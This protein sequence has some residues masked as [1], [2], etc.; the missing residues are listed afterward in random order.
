MKK[1]PRLLLAALAALV[2]AA[3]GTNTMPSA[4]D[5]DRYYAKAEQMAQDR[6]ADLEARKKRGEITQAE[7]EEQSATVRGRILNHATELAWARHENLE[8]RKRAMGIPTGDHP[9]Q[10]IVPGTGGGESFYR[11]AG[12]QGGENFQSNTPY[13]GSTIGG[14]NR[15]D[16]PTLPPLQPPG[17]GA[18]AATG[19]GSS[20]NAGP[21]ARSSPAVLTRTFPCMTSMSARATWLLLP[22]C[23]LLAQC[24]IAHKV[25]Q[26]G[27]DDEPKPAPPDPARRGWALMMSDAEFARFKQG[28]GSGGATSGM[29]PGGP[30]AATG[31]GG[32]MF[33]FSSMLPGQASAGGAVAWQRSAT[34]AAKQARINGTPLL[35]YATH[36]SSVP[37]Q[38]M[39]RTLMASAEFQAL[40]EKFVP[41]LVD[42]S[43]QD[44]SRSDLYRELKNRYDLRGYP[45]LIV[46]LP[47]GTEVTRLTGYNVKTEG[48][49]KTYADT[50][51]RSLTQVDKRTNERRASL[52]RSEGYRLWKNKDGKPVF[53]RLA[54]LDAN[55]GTFTSEWG[56]SFKTFLSRLSEEDQAWIAERRK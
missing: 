48:I 9:V 41:L 19:A 17:T 13:G 40:S 46:A 15:G 55:M 27:K 24:G 14:P 35:I 34:V 25:R 22:C 45:A 37:S 32:G 44:T 21:P 18:S 51:Q 38:Q 2:L 31:D 28:G 53:A 1:S 52:E 12:Q 7:F 11:R 29:D 47:D 39:E 3:C 36:K 5:M 4:T 8:A 56:E 33:D 26:L 49:A 10:V 16:R 54:A 23:L 6:I 30:S 43:D 50:L 42:Y 20:S